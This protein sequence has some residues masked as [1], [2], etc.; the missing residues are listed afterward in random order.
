M[1]KKKIQEFCSNLISFKSIK[2][3]LTFFIGLFLFFIIVK[4]KIPIKF[5]PG[6]YILTGCFFVI[7][8][9]F[10][11]TKINRTIYIVMGISL[12][13]FFTIIKNDS[14]S[15]VLV[16]IIIWVLLFNKSTFDKNKEKDKK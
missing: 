3:I 10:I 13:L 8:T 7:L 4:N 6:I 14:F 11:S 9:P 12:L 1:N 2:S 15:F 5:Y 16:I